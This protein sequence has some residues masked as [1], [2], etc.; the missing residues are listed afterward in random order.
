MGIHVAHVPYTD[1]STAPWQSSGSYPLAGI[2]LDDPGNI[3]GIHTAVSMAYVHDWSMT[4]LSISCE[5]SMRSGSAMVSSLQGRSGRHR[6]LI[7]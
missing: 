1:Q 6:G 5:Q 7:S 3:H 2:S 4:E